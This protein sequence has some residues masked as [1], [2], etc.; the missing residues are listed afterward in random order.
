MQEKRFCHLFLENH[1]FQFIEEKKIKEKFRHN[2]TRCLFVGRHVTY[3][4][5]E[6]LIKAFKHLN[7]DTN[8]LLNIIGEGPLT[9]KLKEYAG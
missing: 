1:L 2:Q 4:G 9:K 8:V 5:I 7:K 3:K 6:V